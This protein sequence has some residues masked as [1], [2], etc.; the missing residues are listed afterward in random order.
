MHKHD[1]G[2][3]IPEVLIATLLTMVVM[4]GALGAFNSAMTLTDT[5]RIV[6]DTNQGMQAA[7]SLMVRDFIQTGQGI[8]KGGIPIPTGGGTAPIVRPAPAGGV[9]YPAACVTMPALAP[10]GRLVSNLL[11][12][13]TDVGV[14]RATGFAGGDTTVGG[15]CGLDDTTSSNTERRGATYERETGSASGSSAAGAGST[16]GWTGAR[17][18]S[19]V[20]AGSTGTC[21]AGGSIGP[22][23]EP[24]RRGSGSSITAGGGVAT[25]SVRSR[26][27][28]GGTSATGSELRSTVRWRNGRSVGRSAGTSDSTGA[29]GAGAADAGSRRANGG[30]TPRAPDSV[31]RSATGTSGSSPSFASAL[32]EA[33]E[34]RIKP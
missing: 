30:S 29:A 4:G 20:G 10:G 1:D 25:V 7:M 2:F 24:E 5:S 14:W 16:I 11:G 31:A 34:I 9:T 23:P 32:L 17:A 12:G 22:E 3:T 6:S 8:P 19:G 21:T 15:N 26:R 33:A 13:T 28:R 27:C 18:G